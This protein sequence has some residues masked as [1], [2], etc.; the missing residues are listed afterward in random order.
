MARSRYRYA[1]GQPPAP[2]V[3]LNLTNPITGAVAGDA[4]ALVDT[5]A[6]QTV[7]PMRLIGLLGL[8]QA[9][10]EVVRG[11]DGT[12]QLLP[13]YI[14]QLQVRDLP[15]IGLEVIGSDKIGNVVLG[16]DVLNRYKLTL[17]GPGQVLEI[18]DE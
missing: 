9:D 16:R 17:D 12:P 3:L 6:D 11:F 2:S 5:G 10:Q 18:T 15:A 8:P 13:T 7:A 1:A 14:V 4:P